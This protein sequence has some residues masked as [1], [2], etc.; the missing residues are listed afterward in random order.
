MDFPQHL[1]G[2]NHDQWRDALFLKRARYFPGFGRPVVDDQNPVITL[3]GLG[4]QQFPQ[5]PE[6][7]VA[8]VGF[9]EI[10]GAAGLH[11][12]QSRGHV[13]A[14]GQKQNRHPQ[15]DLLA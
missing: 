13:V 10:R 14:L 1:Q 8:V 2:L 5:Y 9:V 11:R 12:I 3:R 15:P 7:F 6:H 4:Q